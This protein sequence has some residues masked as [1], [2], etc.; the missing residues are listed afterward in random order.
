[1]KS[2]S[3]ILLSGAAVCCLILPAKGD[4]VFLDEAT[5]VKQAEAIAVVDFEAPQKNPAA[6]NR[7]APG[8]RWRYSIM[9][10]AKTVSVLKGTFSEQFD[11]FG[12]EDFACAKCI[13]SEG[14]FLVFLQKDGMKWVGAN[15]Q[16]SLRPIKDGKIAWYD[17]GERLQFSSQDEAKVIARVKELIARKDD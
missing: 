8:E 5:L 6:G 10:R 4:A 15:W 3:S 16:F 1:M 11:F 2:L 7:A 9:A 13:P 14:R 17:K 12:G